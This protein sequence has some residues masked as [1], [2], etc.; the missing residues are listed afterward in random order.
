MFLDLQRAF[1]PRRVTHK[2]GSFEAAI[3]FNGGELSKKIGF[4]DT[5]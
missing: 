4:L 3:I 1:C 2:G 5:K